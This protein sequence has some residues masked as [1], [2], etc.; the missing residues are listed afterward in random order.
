M[1][2]RGVNTGID[3]VGTSL[4]QAGMNQALNSVGLSD[5]NQN[6]STDSIQSMLLNELALNA[7]SKGL[8]LI[9]RLE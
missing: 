2:G 4:N 6:G 1:N 7:G 3:C 8:D 9:E 5:G